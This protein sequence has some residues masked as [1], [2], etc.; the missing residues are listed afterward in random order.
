MVQGAGE[1][2]RGPFAPVPERRYYRFI[3]GVKVTAA[4][5]RRVREAIGCY[6]NY[7]AQPVEHALAYCRFC[8][9]VKTCVQRVWRRRRPK[10]RRWMEERASGK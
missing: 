10:S 7:Q 1:N 5:L 3:V 6:G 4:E 8:R 9:V 2:A